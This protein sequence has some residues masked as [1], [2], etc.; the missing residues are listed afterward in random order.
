MSEYPNITSV[1]T[2]GQSYQGRDMNL[3]RISTGASDPPK[4]VIW[5]DAGI[6][7]REWIAPAV[8]LYLINQ[9]VEVPENIGL[10]EDVDWLILPSVNPD[11]Y[12]FTWEEV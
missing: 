4:P 3:L 2:I 5:L 6:H 9:L 11:G 12:E 7:A 1:T 8:A 10:I